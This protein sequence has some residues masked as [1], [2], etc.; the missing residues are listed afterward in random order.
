MKMIFAS[1]MTAAAVIVGAQFATTTPASAREYPWCAHYFGEAG[2]APSCG[3]TSYQQCRA[4]I[5]PNDGTCQRNPA[6]GQ[7]RYRH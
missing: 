2:G 4:A 1:A 7:S 5:A 6:Y 3:F